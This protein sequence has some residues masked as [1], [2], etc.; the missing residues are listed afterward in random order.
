MIIAG[1]NEQ[2]RFRSQVWIGLRRGVLLIALLQRDKRA[3]VIRIPIRLRRPVQKTVDTVA[4]HPRLVVA[5]L[6]LV[7]VVRRT[8][9]NV[10]LF[11]RAGERRSREYRP[12]QST[13]AK[14]AEVTRLN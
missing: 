3:V 4:V 1:Q 6:F 9:K 7:V 11:F 13:P 2:L 5:E 8:G 10:A 14:T 12:A